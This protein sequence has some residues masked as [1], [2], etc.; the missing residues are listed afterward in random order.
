MTLDKREECVCIRVD[1]DRAF[2]N[3]MG[4]NTNIPRTFCCVVESPEEEC[5]TINE[6]KN[7]AL[8]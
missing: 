2:A 1:G 3:P 4:P 7:K 5:Q 6:I 8:N